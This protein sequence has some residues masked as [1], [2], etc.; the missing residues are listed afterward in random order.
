MAATTAT[1]RADC[2]QASRAA[3]ARAHLEDGVHRPNVPGIVRGVPLGELRETLGERRA[4]LDVGGR[5][6]VVDELVDDEDDVGRV[7]HAEEQV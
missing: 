5:L 1:A 6:E 3:A 7:G 2:W 4:E